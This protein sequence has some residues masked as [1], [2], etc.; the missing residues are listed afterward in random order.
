MKK[1]LFWK[2]AL[3]AAVS[4]LIVSCGGSDYRNALPGDSFVTLS[5]KAQTLLDKA[6]VGDIKQTALYQ[7]A[8]D[9]FD[10][11][12]V[13][14]AVQEYLLSV[15]AEP[16]KSGLDLKTDAYFFVKMEMDEYGYDTSGEGGMLFK[17]ANKGDFDSFAA[18]LA[19]QGE[20][21]IQ[22]SDNVSM[23]V[24]DDD[25]RSSSI[26][27]Y[28]N[29]AC[30]IYFAQKSYDEVLSRVKELFAQGQS[31]SIMANKAVAAELSSRN[32]LCGVLSLNNLPAA[33]KSEIPNQTLPG[34]AAIMSSTIIM[35]LN[36]EKGKVVMGV[37]TVFDNKEDEKEYKK[38]YDYVGTQSG[39][40]LSFLPLNSIGVVGAN[41]KGAK[42]YEM[43]ASM[44]EFAMVGAVPQV[45]QIMN[46]IDGDM[47]FS[48]KGSTDSPELSLLAN[49]NDASVV[50]AL[51]GI[52][53]MAG[54]PYTEAAPGQYRINLDFFGINIDFGVKNKVLYVTND[55]EVAAAING[56]KIESIAGKF[57]H[58]FKGS[59]GS[60]AVDFDLL[61]P[62]I[63]SAM[64]Y[65]Y[66]SDQ[67][68]Q[69][70]A[71]FDTFEASGSG[72]ESVLVL[73][74]K[75][76]DKNALETIS[77]LTSKLITEAY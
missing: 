28:N 66:G 45:E 69:V 52:A 77:A 62:T 19:E 54:L 20:F 1:R 25:T 12:D 61:M 9:G 18:A 13:P 4:L 75:D 60:V 2:P 37:K 3:I 63:K 29:D 26:L 22:T 16:A 73:N 53:E 8:E 43:I 11:M 48:V 39:K 67:V 70:L 51:T 71:I 72:L 31:Q 57:G 40:L 38:A 6:N 36:F 58:V 21:E 44:R 64:R 47:T 23:I 33:I 32:D 24:I 7:M 65:S 35:P 74:M 27:A 42:I 56:E 46:A 50:E 14:T 68:F 41:L 17:V 76:K 10:D 55:S 49:V 34:M 15:L 59:S 5:F 30:I